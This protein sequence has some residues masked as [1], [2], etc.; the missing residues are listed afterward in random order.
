MKAAVA[1]WA[2]DPGRARRTARDLRS[3]GYGV[4]QVE[5]EAELEELL[6]RRRPEALILEPAGR[7]LPGQGGERWG[8]PVLLV[9]EPGS[10]CTSLCGD[11]ACACLV[12]PVDSALL[13]AGLELAQRCFRRRRRLEFRL[14]RLGQA[15]RRRKQLGRAAGMLMD[16]QGLGEREAR[17]R[18]IRQARQWGIPDEELAEA[19]AQTMR[20][21]FTLEQRRVAPG[22]LRRRLRRRPR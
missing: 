18:I 9:L 13:K 22:V 7:G 2:D 14:R 4:W 5:T 12:E 11:G 3:L 10:R 19:L 21:C 6:Q 20:P 15:L 17:L 8:L 1:L 16:Q